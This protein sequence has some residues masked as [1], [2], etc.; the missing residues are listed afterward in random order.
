MISTWSGVRPVIGSEKSRDPSK[1]RRDHAVWSD[2]GLVTV[3]GGKL[4]TFRLIALDALAAAS[5][6]L[7]D[8]VASSTDQ[9]FQ[10]PT[11]RPEQLTP[12]DRA[13]GQRLLGRYGSAAEQLLALASQEDCAQIDDTKFCLA[14][15][16]WAIAHEAVIH[17]DDLLLRRT[18]LG[19]LLQNGGEQLFDQLQVIFSELR[20]WDAQRWQQE[21]DRYRNI[22]AS[23]YSLPGAVPAH[24]IG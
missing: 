12:G 3:S 5:S 13:W 24:A 6:R 14:E 15:C 9:I 2:K 18:R 17:L 19:L 23:Y 7:P 8:P 21:V 20:G 1:E 16:R 22:W 4:T 10:V 11:A